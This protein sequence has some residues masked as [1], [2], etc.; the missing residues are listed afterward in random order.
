MYCT[1]L[2]SV[3]SVEDHSRLTCPGAWK[4]NFRFGIFS[5]EPPKDL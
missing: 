2:Q 3:Y 1:A 5:W 4:V